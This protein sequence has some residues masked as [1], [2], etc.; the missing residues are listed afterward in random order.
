MF[1]LLIIF[2]IIAVTGVLERFV[3]AEDGPIIFQV[4]STVEGKDANIGDGICEDENGNCTLRAAVEEANAYK[5]GEQVEI[6]LPEGTYSPVYPLGQYTLEGN[7]RIVGAGEG[8]T[9]ID[10]DTVMI[11]SRIFKIDRNAEV[12]IS[13]VTMTGGRAQSHNP[14]DNPAEKAYGGAIW[15]SGILSL[16]DVMIT[17]NASYYLG[18]AIYNESGGEITLNNSTITE[19]GEH[20]FG[21]VDSGGGIYQAE[22][23]SLTLINSS[24]I[25]NTA[26]GGGGIYNKGGTVVIEESTISGNNA[27]DWYGG[28]FSEGSLTIRSSEISENTAD[29]NGGGIYFGFS[30]GTLNIESSKINNNSAENGAGIFVYVHKQSSATSSLSVV[31]SHISGN[32]ASNDGGGVYIGLDSSGEIVSLENNHIVGNDAGNKGASLFNSTPNPIQ[33]KHNWWGSSG[34]AGKQEGEAI[35]FPWWVNEEM[36][37]QAGNA[38]LLNR[39]TVQGETMNPSYSPEIN[40]Y[41][42]NPT[43]AVELR[44]TG[45]VADSESSLS[46]NGNAAVSGEVTSIPLEIGVNMIEVMVTTKDGWTNVY[47]L[48]VSRTLKSYVVDKQYSGY[49]PTAV[50]VGLDGRVYY[51]SFDY[52]IV[53]RLDSSLENETR[54]ATG[55]NRPWGI[56]VDADSHIY[57]ADYGSYHF[58]KLAAGGTEIKRIGGYGTGDG[59]FNRPQGLAIDGNGHIYIADRQNKRIQIFDTNLEYISEFTDVGQYPNLEDVAVSHEGFTYVVYNHRY[60]E[61]RIIKL[62]KNGNEIHSWGGEGSSQ[63]QFN[64]PK[65]IAVDSAGYVYVAD[66]DN[67][68]VQIF[69][70]NGTYLSEIV[71]FVKPS[72]IAFDTEGNLYVARENGITKLRVLSNDATLKTLQTSEGS[73]QPTFSPNETDYTIEVDYSVERLNLA[74]EVNNSKSIITVSDTQY[75][76]GNPIEVVLEEGLNSVTLQVRAENGSVIDYLVEI[77]RKSL[78]ND[79]TLKTLQTSAGSLQPTFSPNETDYMIEVD[80]TVEKLDLTAEANDLKSVITVSGTQYNS[81]QPIEVELVEGSNGVAIQVRA[82]S[83]AVLN[84]VVEVYRQAAPDVEGPTW[85]TGSELAVT[86]ITRTSMQLNWPEATDNVAVEGYRIYV[87]GNLIDTLTT[88]ITEYEVRNL[89]ANRNYTFAVEAFDTSHN[90]SENRLIKEAKTRANLPIGGGWVPSGNANLG[91]LT[92]LADGEALPL[93]PTFSNDQTD[94]YLETEYSQIRLKVSAAHAAGKITLND[95]RV[96]GELILDL[97][98]GINMFNLTVQSENG[99]KKKYTLSIHRISQVPYKVFNK[100]GTYTKNKLWTVA[101]S[102]EVDAS[103]VQDSLYVIDE[104]GM[105]IPVTFTSD[106]KEIFIHAPVDEYVAGIYTLY[107]TSKLKDKN[108]TNLQEPIKMTFTIK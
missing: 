9:I 32:Q 3:F 11:S 48:E 90:E 33:A 8:K 45:V 4:N 66:Q 40:R 20:S 70:E 96:Q 93:T 26:E 98:E 95:E 18:G 35:V 39:L 63:G 49:T 61:E 108:G 78:S 75:N 34:P 31:D 102:K 84:Y 83:G 2:Q 74:A 7:V 99:T 29:G 59:Q 16:S 81:G 10:F 28:I 41:K 105:V 17:K 68:R 54:L 22:N 87:N 77:N 67:H 76:S 72:S 82:E 46:I 47:T 86:N 50:T 37:E 103:S 27:T 42:L 21:I 19:N 15:N 80:H 65:G 57:V 97:Q 88:G 106:G 55:F 60:N 104:K 64:N 73:L 38:L 44:L 62:D 53:T 91:Q 25:N 107:I 13:G 79:A 89:T 5:G 6:Q 14:S 12:S 30:G 85:A 94:Y 24:V 69:D 92:L 71:G 36:N 52:K 43:E 101:L 1:S 100:E 58:I 56:A 23:A 51:T